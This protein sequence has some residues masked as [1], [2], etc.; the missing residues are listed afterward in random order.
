LQYTSRM[1]SMNDGAGTARIV[2]VLLAAGAATRFGSNKLLHPLPDGR[3]IALVSA[4][5]LRAALPETIVMVRPDNAGLGELLAQHGIAHVIAARAA[6]GM[7][8]SLAQGVASAARADGWV[9]ALA[10][11]PY[12]QRATIAGIAQAL[13]D[14]AQIAA[15]VYRGQ[16][17]H[18]VGFAAR[19]GE[20]LL[21]LQGDEGARSVVRGHASEVTEIECD[22]A[23]VIADIDRPSDLAFRSG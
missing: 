12:L 23:G 7:G 16:R 21:Q 2:G 9:V 5:N 11:M 22:D 8:A 15:P 3:P 13:R 17:G 19:F 10:D 14:G 6:E 18:P 4:L 1:S 20:A